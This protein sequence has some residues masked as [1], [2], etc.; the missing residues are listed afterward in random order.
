MPK[1]KAKATWLENVRSAVDNQRTHSIVCD[2]STPAGGTDTGPTA[3]ELA[4]MALA[5]CGVTIFADVCRKSNIQPNKVEV[6]V[7]ADK[8]PESP[9]VTGVT[10]K[11][12]VASKARKELLEAAWRRTEANCPVLNIFKDPT[13]VKVEFESKTE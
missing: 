10:M 2:L 7:E 9:A 3:L 12:I 4:M 13:P 1:I 6:T 8:A 5:D 11:V